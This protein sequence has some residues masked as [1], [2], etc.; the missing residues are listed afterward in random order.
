MKTNRI[1]EWIK[2]PAGNYTIIGL[3]SIIGIVVV[4]SLFFTGE[5]IKVKKEVG[6]EADT[7]VNVKDTSF[8][9]NSNIYYVTGKKGDK[10]IMKEDDFMD[11]KDNV[12]QL[13]DV[14]DNADS[15]TVK[16][17]NYQRI[18]D[19]I[20][21]ANDQKIQY[22]EVKAKK[23]SYK[24]LQNK[25]QY[26][27]DWRKRAEQE[28]DAFF[29]TPNVTSQ[30][31]RINNQNLKTDPEIYAVL[32]NDQ[33]VSNKERIS[34][35]LGQEAI[36]KGIKYKRNTIFYGFVSFSKNRIYVNVNSISL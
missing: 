30:N 27:D 16:E 1:S 15:I 33:T 31:K 21:A 22:K 29:N 23:E 5:E 11:F 20:L 35:R 14:V 24:K 8:K 13:K 36:I 28:N 4:Y 2:T 19:S 6:E 18:A 10:K 32:F 3:L 26:R 9:K 7:N 17:V 12:E 25:S 34:L